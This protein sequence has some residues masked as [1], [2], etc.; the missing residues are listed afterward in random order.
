[1]RDVM[2]VIKY[3][4]KIKVTN[5]LS[6]SQQVVNLIRNFIILLTIMLKSFSG[7]SN[8]IQIFVFIVDSL[9]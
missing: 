4:W 3:F 7:I 2:W 1:M 6:V 9:N 5:A 8:Y